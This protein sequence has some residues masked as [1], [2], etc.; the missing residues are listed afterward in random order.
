MGMT[1][2]HR[3]GS[4]VTCFDCGEVGCM[5]CYTHHPDGYYL[6]LEHYWGLIDKRIDHVF[7]IDSRFTHLISSRASLSLFIAHR[8]GRTESLL[9]QPKEIL[10]EF[11]RKIYRVEVSS[12]PENRRAR[13]GKV[14]WIDETKNTAE[15]E[16]VD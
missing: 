11:S 9:W 5:L 7:K 4:L 8:I 16:R 6:C 10:K 2:S 13:V 14:M 12:P 3:I 1:C 15:W